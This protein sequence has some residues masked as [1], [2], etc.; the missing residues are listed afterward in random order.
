MSGLISGLIDGLTKEEQTSFFVRF[1]KLFLRPDLHV[2]SQRPERKSKAAKSGAVLTT[3]A[4]K[5]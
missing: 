4:V 5:M 1:T 3:I 2:S